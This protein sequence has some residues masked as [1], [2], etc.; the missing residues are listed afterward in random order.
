MAEDLVVNQ[1]HQDQNFG[2]YQVSLRDV[3]RACA[4]TIFVNAFLKRKN[5][6]LVL[7]LPF[8]I[9]HRTKEGKTIFLNSQRV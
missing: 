3:N 5:K 7:F 6:Y 1:G 8:V 9:M 4:L 2:Y